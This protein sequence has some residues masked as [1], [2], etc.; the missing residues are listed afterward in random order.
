MFPLSYDKLKCM[1]PFTLIIFGI[2]SNLAQIKLI[3]TL[4]DLV[5]SREF[6]SD[7]TVIGVGRT[8]MDQA[9]F[10][11]FIGQVLRSQNRHHTHAI[12]SAIERKL[13]SH[14]TYLPIDL[15]SPDSYVHLKTLIKANPHSKNRMI[16]LATYPS[17]YNSIFSQLKSVR[18][19]G[20]KNGWTRVL[21]EKPIGSDRDSAAQLNEMLAGY[22]VE[23]QIF[24]LDHYLGK[25]TLHD[26]LKFRFENGVL[27]SNIQATHLDH[28]QV[29]A[30]EDFGIGLRG[31]YYDQNGAL[32]DVGQN[33]L[34][35]M[36][37]LATMAQPREFTND[38]VT[39]ERVN[40]L[41]NLVPEPDTLV[42]GQYQGYHSEPHV[43]K[44]SD[45][46]TY[47]AF[48]TSIDNDRFMGVPIYVRG[49]KYLQATS[50]EVK[51]VFKNTNVLTY[52]IS[53]QGGIILN[54]P[55]S[56]TQFIKPRTGD[57]PDAYQRLMLDALAGDQTYFNDAAEI[58]AQW[59][60]TD[61]LLAQKHGM[62]PIVYPRGSWGPK[63][64]DELIA[65]DGR[66]WL[67]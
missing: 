42:L 30:A 56:S 9:S 60:F 38:L 5:A 11:S 37:A 7:F 35:Q 40:I 13:L 24:R 41:T 64:A 2:T 34:L 46:E 18:L 44:D 53:A 28:I 49:G 29:T 12:D 54:T 27:E 3:P 16:Y 59:A 55:N 63:E 62:Q 23:D 58:D 39:Q 67:T 19:T 52:R 57:E 32:K 51:I 1:E 65:R 22:F 33:H 48:R 36:I 45:T 17:L 21:I 25:E 15:T 66:A 8:P 4:Y 20:Q 61:S 6:S 43:A 14:L 10:T 26:I 31:S 47:F 50:T